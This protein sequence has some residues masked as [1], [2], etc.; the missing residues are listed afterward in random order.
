[1]SI[2]DNTEES[3]AIVCCSSLFCMGDHLSCFHND[4]AILKE[5]GFAA[6]HLGSE[7]AINGGHFSVNVEASRFERRM[8]L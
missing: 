6:I 7:L 5:D 8:K 2:A 3:G 4:A 1:V